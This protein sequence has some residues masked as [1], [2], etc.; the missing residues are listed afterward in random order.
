MATLNFYYRSKKAE[1]FLTAKLRISI[2]KTNHVKT[3]KVPIK[4]NINIWKKIDAIKIKPRSLKYDVNS[5]KKELSKLENY[6]IESIDDESDE[7]RILSDNWLDKQIENYLNPKSDISEFLV[8]YVDFFLESRKN[9]IKAH[10]KLKMSGLK[11][12][13]IE[14]EEKNNHRLKISEIDEN[15]KSSFL[16]FLNDKDYSQNYIKKNFTYIKQ[17][18]NHA[19]YNGLKVSPQLNKISIKAEKT[20]KIYLSFEELEN[21]ENT[22]LDSENLKAT[23]DWLIISAYTG[24]RISDFMRFRIGM[25]R[26]EKGKHL[27]EFTQKKTNKTMTIPLHKK[28]LEV[29][30]NNSNKFPKQLIDSK[31]NKYLKDVCKIAKI[32]EPTTGRKLVNIGTEKDPVFRM[33]TDVYPKY[34]LISSH[35]GRR[36][37]ATNFYGEIPTTFLIYITGHSTEAMFL[38]YIGKSNKDLALEVANYFN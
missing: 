19:H 37:F 2:D 33:I 36:S 17:L 11:K 16:Q 14:F 1:A 15:F 6:I 5:L 26:K 13:L 30:E 21:I 32:N 28:V 34:D 18:C 20:P 31:Y 22:E 29:I 7:L 25:I 9:E 23:R 35:V 38:N 27:L 4:T 3:A 12:K 8:D 24:Q 10:Y